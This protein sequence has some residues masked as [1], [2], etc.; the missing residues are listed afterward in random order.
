MAARPTGLGAFAREPIRRGGRLAAGGWAL[1]DAP[2]ERPE[3]GEPQRPAQNTATRLFNIMISLSFLL[4]FC[5]TFSS[6]VT[7]SCYFT[8]SEQETLLHFHR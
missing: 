7:T 8:G 6:L 5:R 1:G 4:G 2:G 3:R